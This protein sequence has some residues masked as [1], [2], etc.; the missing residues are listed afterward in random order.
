M[1]G[2]VSGG[3]SSAPGRRGVRLPAPGGGGRGRTPLPATRCAWHGYLQCES[4]RQG[5]ILSVQNPPQFTSWVGVPD[6]GL[7]PSD[8]PRCLSHQ[9]A[10]HTG[11]SGLLGSCQAGTTRAGAHQSRCLFRPEPNATL[12]QWWRVV[13]GLFP[14]RAGH[15]NPDSSL[16][17]HE[18]CCLVPR[19]LPPGTPRDTHPRDFFSDRDY[20]DTVTT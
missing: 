3:D 5:S 6:I 14:R 10:A 9:W 1:K 4:R 7:W 20:L 18:S 19:P 13:R 2:W 12:R 11:A 17:Y 16:T 8:P 15:G